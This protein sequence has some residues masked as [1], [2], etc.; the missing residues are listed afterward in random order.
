MAK[1]IIKNGYIKPENKK[2]V[3]SLVKYIATRDGVEL[4]HNVNELSTKA[5][6]DLIKQ[7]IKDYPQSVESYEYKDY[8]VQQ[9]KVNASEFISSVLDEVA[10]KEVGRERYVKYIAERPRVELVS[11]N[12]LFNGSRQ[13]INL[14]HVIKELSE[15]KGNVWTPIISLSREDAKL[16]GYESAKEWQGLISENLS[17]IADCMKIKDSNIRW[18]AAFHN[19]GH[20]PH[21]HMICYSV[22]EREGY[23]TKPGIEKM[24]SVLQNEIFKEQLIPLYAKKTKA[25]DELK[26]EAKKVFKLI[27][28]NDIKIDSERFNVLVKELS[29]ELKNVKGKKQYG[30]LS[31]KIKNIVDDIVDEIANEPSVKKGY[32][33]WKELQEEIVGGYKDGAAEDIP[34]SKQKEF[35]SIKNMII[36][37]TIELGRKV[38]D[39][40]EVAQASFK[41]L[42]AISKMLESKLPRDSTTQAQR[43]DSKS[44]RRL[45]ELKESRG[46][47]HTGEDL[48]NNNVGM[49][50]Y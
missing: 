30:Y 34:L 20:H 37:E 13:D 8:L 3:S 41:L 36:N 39:T 19:E 45:K 22:D 31:T 50:T 18:Y 12:G 40:Q 49:Q 48:E 2:H 35:K 7:I 27:N 9:T 43:V 32:E 21:I 24:K 29:R 46:L 42:K 38:N 47:K 15:H 17:K 23:L 44:L 33:L 16:T 26:E 14:S 25:R 10:N 6:K 11:T 4:V 5:Q 1:L 28:S